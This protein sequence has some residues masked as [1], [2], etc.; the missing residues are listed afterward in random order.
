[1]ILANLRR[2]SVL[3]LTT[4]PISGCDDVSVIFSYPKSKIQAG[5]EKQKFV[6]GDEI[7]NAESFSKFC[8]IAPLM[9]LRKFSNIERRVFFSEE[10]YFTMGVKENGDEVIERIHSTWVRTPNG[11][12]ICAEKGETILVAMVDE[13]HRLHLILSER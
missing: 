12:T 5:A 7:F 13:N 11:N 1:M 10:F 3:A 6:E 8:L 9:D 4:L 2:L